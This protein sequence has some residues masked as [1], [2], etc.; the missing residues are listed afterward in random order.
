MRPESTVQNLT[1]LEHCKATNGHAW[2]NNVGAYVDEFGRQVR[3]GLANES[4][5]END[6]IKSSD[7]ICTTPEWVYHP[8]R[9]WCW[10]AVLTA[11][12]CKP[13]GWRQLPGDKR[14]LAQANFHDIVRSVGGYAGFVTDPM[15]L[16]RIVGRG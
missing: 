2:R 4:K 9:G 14:A 11:Y 1:R 16:Y 12:E 10:L 5:Q 8:V 13:E 6:Q 7:L 3:Y 15:D